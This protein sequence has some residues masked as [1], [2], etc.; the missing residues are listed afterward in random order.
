MDKPL[1]LRVAELLE[2]TWEEKFLA[3]AI[4][5]QGSS[6][7]CEA[8]LIIFGIPLPDCLLLLVKRTI[9]ERGPNTL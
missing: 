8:S 4:N 6:A 3:A 9:H 1:P 5:L 7:S 2:E